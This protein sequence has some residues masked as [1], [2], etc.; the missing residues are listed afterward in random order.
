[1][2]LK[3]CVGT[4][5]QKSN[6]VAVIQTKEAA[7][8][9]AAFLLSNPKL[10]AIDTETEGIDPKSQSPVKTG[11]IVCWSLAY[12]TK[13][14]VLRYFL[15]WKDEIVKP[16]I[17]WFE[18]H[19]HKK[20]GHNI[21]NFD[22]HVINNMGVTINGISSDTLFKA[23][24]YKTDKNFSVSLKSL[25]T[26]FLGYESNSFGSLFSVPKKGEIVT[27]TKIGKSNRKLNGKKIPTVLG[28][29]AT[30]VSFKTKEFIKLSDIPELYPDKLQAL[31]DYASLDAKACLEL[32]FELDKL[33]PN[34]H[35]FYGVWF[36]SLLAW[37]DMAARGIQ[38]DTSEIDRAKKGAEESLVKAESKL[39]KEIN[40]SSPKQLAE[41]LYVKKNYPIPSIVGGLKS[42]RK[43]FEK[44]PS[45][46]AA[47]LH[48]IMDKVPESRELLKNILELRD[49]KADIAK[50][51]SYYKF[52]V[53]NRVYPIS[54]ASTDTGR[55][56]VSNPAIQQVNSADRDKFKLRKAFIAKKN[57]KLVVADFS[58]LEL[59]ILAHYMIKWFKDT[60]LKDALLSSD[61][62]SFIAKLAWPHLD[63]YEGNLKK[64]GKEIKAYRDKVKN[65]VYG[66]IYGKTASGLGL[67]IKQNKIPI[68]KKKA[69]ELINVVESAIGFKKYSNKVISYAH[70]H[71][72]V[73]TIGGRTRPLSNIHYKELQSSEERKALNT[74]I[75]GGAAD[76]VAACAV[77]LKF[78]LVMQIHDEL[79]LEVKAEEAQ[80][81]EKHLVRVMQKR[82]FNLAI[83][84]KA[85]SCICSNWSEAK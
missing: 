70:Q 61:V 71:G 43:N 14:G 56:A 52:L 22:R 13:V 28:Y 73:H 1:M 62:H 31:Y 82:R 74:P 33:L 65:I 10:V 24:Y 63:K 60:R 37:S 39:P 58:Q 3:N 5:A 11:K 42:I 27:R 68:G 81:A 21:L 69:Q 51:K 55:L 4:S 36:D 20:T 72:C 44:K 53:N 25:M 15:W 54:K 66:I 32:E 6:G 2:L 48:W 29:Y 85:D 40:F 12:K 75:Q 76:I 30:K 67:S 57:H 77:D 45:T 17:P 23:K 16:F 59:Y 50:C 18:S 34:D 47:S 35:K 46:S 38:I 49:C 19:K 80:E 83:G 84:L 41:L 7:S 79:V 26:K 64:H 8:Y 78:P 9:L